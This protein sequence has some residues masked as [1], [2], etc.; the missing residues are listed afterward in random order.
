MP[1][2]HSILIPGQIKAFVAG[3]NRGGTISGVVR[4]AARWT[5]ITEPG[6]IPIRTQFPQFRSPPVTYVLNPE[7]LT[8]SEDVLEPYLRI[9]GIHKRIHSH[10]YIKLAVYTGV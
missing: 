6:I 8:T 2:Q 9:G 4:L 3:F 7:L 10:S 1:I 5:T